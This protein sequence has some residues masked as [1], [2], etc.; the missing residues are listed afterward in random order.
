MMSLAGDEGWQKP[1]H[2]LAARGTPKFCFARSRMRLKAL[3][4]RQPAN[5]VTLRA[6]DAAQSGTRRTGTA[7]RDRQQVIARRAGRR[8]K[9]AFAEGAAADDAASRPSLAS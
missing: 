6:W 9:P 1:V 2:L 7:P 5:S 3:T 4:S 8:I